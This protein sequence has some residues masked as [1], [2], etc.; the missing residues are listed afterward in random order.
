ML[1]S[2]LPWFLVT[3]AVYFGFG[4]LI[5]SFGNADSIDYLHHT[6]PVDQHLLRYTSL[7]TTACTL[8]VCVTY[9]LGS[10]LTSWS[11][12]AGR[13][14]Y[15]RV[16]LDRAIGACLVIGVTIRYGILAVGRLASGDSFIPSQISSL[17]DFILLAILLM[18]YTLAR[19]DRKWGS[20]FWPLFAWELLLRVSGSAK[21]EVIFLLLPCV[22]GL[23][24]ARPS[25]K[26]LAATVVLGAV[27]WQ[28]LVPVS[29]AIRRELR[30]G[31]GNTIS[32]RLAL[33]PEVLSGEI[34]IRDRGVTVS[35]P[36]W[37]RLTYNAPQSFCIDRYDQGNPGETIT[38]DYLYWCF[39]PRIVA[40][41]KPEMT[42][43]QMFNEVLT[44]N[45]QSKSAP[46][47]FAEAYWNGGWP[48]ALGVSVYFGV[49]CVVMTAVSARC[50]STGNY[51]WLPL[52]WCGLT[53]GLR[54]D[55]W[56]V[57]TY[58]GSPLAALSGCLILYMALPGLHTAR[59]EPRAPIPGE[60]PPFRAL[61]RGEAQRG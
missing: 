28:L 17:G 10:Q 22:F 35:Q 26:V 46:G 55:D 18:S 4:P 41:E 13:P 14:A 34:E 20:V 31:R 16:F 8:T 12:P 43:G 27:L 1:L 32:D 37:A 57:A 19:G 61:P 30:A 38:L 3:S 21:Y 47:F 49:L 59:G 39:V 33:V 44:G 5:Y 52:V 25:W 45:S 36:W 23:Y 24:L 53:M 58:V 51:R 54:P 42:L 48:L 7:L 40:P 9:Y 50:L 6:Y 2:P 11:F 15:D 29:T 60:R 56:F